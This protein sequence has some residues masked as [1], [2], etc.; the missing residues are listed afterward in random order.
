MKPPKSPLIR[1]GS[2]TSLAE[3]VCSWKH[4]RSYSK[5]FQSKEYDVYCGFIHLEFREDEKASQ[6]VKHAWDRYLRVRKA[7]REAW[8]GSGSCVYVV[9][10]HHFTKAMIT[11]SLEDEKWNWKIPISADRAK[12]LLFELNDADSVKRKSSG[13]V[14][15]LKVPD[16]PKNEVSNLVCELRG[17]DGGDND[18]DSNIGKISL[19]SE[20]SSFVSLGSIGTMEMSGEFETISDEE[21][22]DPLLQTL[23]RQ[24]TGLPRAM[25]KESSD[26]EPENL[27]LE[28]KDSKPGYINVRTSDNQ[29]GGASKSMSSFGSKQDVLIELLESNIVHLQNSARGMGEKD[30]AGSKVKELEL[31]L[32][33]EQAKHEVTKLKLDKAETKIKEAISVSRNLQ[34]VQLSLQKY[35]ELVRSLGERFLNRLPANQNMVAKLKSLL[36]E[37][38]TCMEL[39]EERDAVQRSRIADMEYEIEAMKTKRGSNGGSGSDHDQLDDLREKLVEKDEQIAAFRIKVGE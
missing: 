16:M 17:L 24:P 13:E 27:N 22:A 25:T 14:G 38:L 35:Q 28:V 4:C 23:E 29:T 9:A 30:W 7:T 5:V 37:S 12:V 6:V 18:E 8:K 33:T 32:E 3:C 39:L 34:S 19:H 11:E 36:E 15:Y 21:E 31:A 26:V 10:R 20:V 1:Q 2:S